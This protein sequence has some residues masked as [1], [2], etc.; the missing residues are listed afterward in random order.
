[1]SKSLRE[2]AIYRRTVDIKNSGKKTSICRRERMADLKSACCLS[3][4]GPSTSG[5]GTA[6][7]NATCP[8][9]SLATTR[10]RCGDIPLGAYKAGAFANSL[11]G[12]LDN[13]MPYL[14]GLARLCSN[15]HVMSLGMLASAVGR[16]AAVGRGKEKRREERRQTRKHKRQNN[17]QEDK[18][19]LT[20]TGSIQLV[21]PVPMEQL[22]QQGTISAKDVLGQESELDE[23][24]LSSPRYTRKESYPRQVQ[25]HVHR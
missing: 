17:S 24:A 25:L 10:A 9:Y 1:M 14:R 6:S 8:R 20:I 18:G 3:S 7:R 5:R 19:L 22:K 15:R 12:I 23:L 13:N 4:I 11:Q 2:K 21:G 16:A